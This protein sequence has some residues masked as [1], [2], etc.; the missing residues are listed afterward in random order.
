MEFCN[1]ITEG[2]GPLPE[3]LVSSI[4]AMVQTVIE[5]CDTFLPCRPWVDQCR[6]TGSQVGT[7]DLS[8][9]LPLLPTEDSDQGPAH[10]DAPAGAG[11]RQQA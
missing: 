4:G 6:C 11:R 7:D 8:Q 1:A 3:V 9:L 5:D 10:G 2:F